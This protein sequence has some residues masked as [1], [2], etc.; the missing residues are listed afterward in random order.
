[1]FGCPH[2]DG[3]SLRADYPRH[4]R[5]AHT[6]IIAMYIYSDIIVKSVISSSFR[7]GIIVASGMRVST[8][9]LSA[10]PHLATEPL[11]KPQQLIAA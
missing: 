11:K 4:R 5:A 9:H 3:L 10:A 8:P 7:S 2:F 1:M 6:A